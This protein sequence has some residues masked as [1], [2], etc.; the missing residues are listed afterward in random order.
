M[1]VHIIDLW[2]NTLRPVCQTRRF[3]FIVVDPDRGTCPDC[4][5][6]VAA[7]RIVDRLEVR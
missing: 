5:A 2:A 7:A 4:L 1:T 6:L 3:A